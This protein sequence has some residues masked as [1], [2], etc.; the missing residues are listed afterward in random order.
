MLSVLDLS[1]VI[2]RVMV[3]GL[4]WREQVPVAQRVNTERS[5][6]AFYRL[7][8]GDHFSRHMAT[9][10]WVFLRTYALE[11]QAWG[12]RPS[13]VPLAHGSPHS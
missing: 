13:G 5:P 8:S 4:R 11:S 9:M 6:S 3:W 1:A 10:V 7:P 2:L 12:S